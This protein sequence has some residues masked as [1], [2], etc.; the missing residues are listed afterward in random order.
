MVF[1]GVGLGGV[2]L[3]QFP[4]KMIYSGS[5]HIP[6]WVNW[7]RRSMSLRLLENMISHC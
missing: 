6:S 5:V 1:A 3:A 2:K 7:I 4:G